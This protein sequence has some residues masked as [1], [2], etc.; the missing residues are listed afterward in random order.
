LPTSPEIPEHWHF[1]GLRKF[2]MSPSAIADLLDSS[3]VWESAFAVFLTG[4][5]AFLRR[6][7]AR[8][9]GEEVYSAQKLLPQYCLRVNFLVND[10]FPAA[11]ATFKENQRLG[12]RYKYGP[13]AWQNRRTNPSAS[14]RRNAPGT[15]TVWA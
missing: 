2:V 7:A 9:D 15:K 1:D 5:D 12:R 3:I 10:E 13:P 4:N 11:K 8:C 6:L 14:P